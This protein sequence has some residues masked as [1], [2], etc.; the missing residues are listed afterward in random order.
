M[1]CIVIESAVPYLTLPQAHHHLGGTN[2]SSKAELLHRMIVL[3]EAIQQY[4]GRR[5]AEPVGRLTPVTDH[6]DDATLITRQS[7]NGLILGIV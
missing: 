6:H 1:K 4:V 5:A 3:G 7:L 2:V